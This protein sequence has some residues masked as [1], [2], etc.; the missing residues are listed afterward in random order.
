VPCEVVRPVKDVWSRVD[1]K[2]TFDGS[3]PGG[4]MGASVLGLLGDDD[5]EELV[6]LGRAFP[7]ERDVQRELE[8]AQGVLDLG[9]HRV[10]DHFE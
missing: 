8:A 1:R 4:V 3:Y 9:T 2:V 6:V 7:R 10:L 5:L